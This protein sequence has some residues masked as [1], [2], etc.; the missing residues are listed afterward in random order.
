M[1]YSHELLA[2]KSP[3][4]LVW[5][6]ATN[7]TTR[8]VSGKHAI[9]RRHVLSQNIV[10]KCVAIMHPSAPLALR[11]SSILQLG[12]V[13]L[14]KKQVDYLLED[15]AA[16]LAKLRVVAYSHAN[17]LPKKGGKRG[18]STLLLPSQRGN[19]TI[20]SLFIL[21][22]QQGGEDGVGDDEPLLLLI[23]PLLEQH[24]PPL[25]GDSSKK[26]KRGTTMTSSGLTLAEDS[27]QH[28]LADDSDVDY[29]IINPGDAMVDVSE[30]GEFFLPQSLPA[31]LQMIGGGGGGTNAAARMHTASG[32]AED[33]GDGAMLLSG[34]GD[35]VLLLPVDDA[36]VTLA[37]DYY[38]NDDGEEM[39]PVIG[40]GG[41]DDDD[42]GMPLPMGGDD[43]DAD[44]LPPPTTPTTP[45]GDGRL[46]P[47]PLR[48]AMKK[49]RASGRRRVALV[50]E[51][52]TI[53]SAT[54]RAWT[55]GAP[56][57][58][59][60]I[61]LPHG[62]AGTTNTT[63]GGGSS[64]SLSAAASH[65]L[66]RR[67]LTTPAVGIHNPTN[68]FMTHDIN[69]AAAIASDVALYGDGS[70]EAIASRAAAAH[71][72]LWLRKVMSK[73]AVVAGINDDEYD[74]DGKNKK[75]RS[76]RRKLS[77]S[78]DGDGVLVGVGDED[79]AMPMPMPMDDD[80]DMMMPLPP[81]L[82]EDDARADNDFALLGGGDATVEEV[83][84]ERL[85]AAVLSATPASK[86]GS[87]YSPS[88]RLASTPGTRG[89]V[90]S[91]RQSGL[92][93][94][95]D[96]ED[97]VPLLPE[98][99]D[100][101]PDIDDTQATGLLEE[102]QQASLRAVGADS[103]VNATLL[104][105]LREA[106]DAGVPHVSFQRAAK[107]MRSRRKAARLFL[108]VLELMSANFVILEQ[109]HEDELLIKR[110]MAL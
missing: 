76:K 98:E 104:Q 59:Q 46:S 36:A 48:S 13:K 39:L 61:T 34:G 88:L 6:L 95:K 66:L 70:A 37:G 93:S 99:D 15:S 65:A 91:V 47:P 41:H 84:V 100:V 30:G 67:I 83:E 51:V 18:S 78:E 89:G 16:F 86:G 20:D 74:D 4:G 77:E 75:K 71:V 26:R 73:S 94:V 1:F 92:D 60:S 97:D 55:K 103:A 62:A 24:L 33:S 58:L 14:Y 82:S 90:R 21:Q 38:N 44:L 19:Q 2:R 12:V 87:L 10:E 42:M 40:G 107:G 11:L 35:D 54:Y 45:D 32:R 22:Q 106:F 25:L 23:D 109:E 9:A 31:H 101:L 81:A 8:G 56:D 53:P 27:R 57:H 79:D 17:L 5:A 28:I 49:K 64:S 80:D 3:L 7:N 52:T 105:V 102:T 63:R 108:N 68:H 50:D 69:A 110:G 85:R 96:D 72:P 29:L 43:D